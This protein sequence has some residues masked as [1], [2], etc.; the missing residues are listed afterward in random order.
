MADLFVDLDEPFRSEADEVAGAANR[1]G[2]VRV[3]LKVAGCERSE[4][5]TAAGD[6]VDGDGSSGEVGFERFDFRDRRGSGWGG[7]EEAQVARSE[8]VVE[9]GAARC[10]IGGE[11]VVDG[12]VEEGVADVGELREDDH[13]GGLSGL[14]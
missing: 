14:V 1:A 11:R 3:E 12:V 5:V 2:G 8:S 10:D 6:D 4:V 7:A 13:G 9:A